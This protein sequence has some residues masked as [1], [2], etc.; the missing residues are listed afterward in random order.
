MTRDTWEK[1]M[2]DSAFYKGYIIQAAPYKLA[3]SGEFTINISILHNTGSDINARN[4]SAVNT[5]KTKEEAIQH[6]I[7][8]GRQIIDGDFELENSDTSQ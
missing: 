5:F 4:F 3:D 7:N 2:V 1:I 6:C 8:F